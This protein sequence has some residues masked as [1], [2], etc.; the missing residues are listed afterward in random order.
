[1][2]EKPTESR[3]G[4]AWAVAVLALAAG[5]AL[6]ETGPTVAAGPAPPM[7]PSSETGAPG[8]ARPDSTQPSAK[9]SGGAADKTAPAPAAAPGR[10][11]PHA[12]PAISPEQVRSAQ[13][14]AQARREAL[15]RPTAGAGDP[16]TMQTL[17]ERWGVESKGVRRTARGYMIDFRFRV[18]DAEKARPLFDP[19]IKPFLLAED[20]G[21]RLPVPV[22]QKVGA[23]RTTDRG[24]NIQA[25]K[26]YYMLFA[27]P[28]AFLE[29]GARVAVVIGE[30]R[31]PHLTLD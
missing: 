24:R 12:K 1:M 11:A 5:L 6:A 14:D 21:V 26:D 17:A 7:A 31:L 4:G 28:D 22:G 2:T 30:F 13:R 15:L 8:P 3:G 18:L 10:A 19:R 16:Q 25:G 23:F 27:N 29:P 9:D 20:S